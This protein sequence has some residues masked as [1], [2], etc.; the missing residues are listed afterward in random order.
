[1]NVAL[2]FPQPCPPP[3]PC[4]LAWFRAPQRPETMQIAYFRALRAPKPCK[5]RGFGHLRGLKPCKQ[6]GF[7]H[8]RGPKL[9]KQCTLSSAIELPEVL[10]NTTRNTAYY[11]VFWIGL[12]CFLA[13]ILHIIHCFGILVFGLLH[14]MPC[15]FLAGSLISAE[16]HCTTLSM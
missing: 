13:G 2:P 4:T 9:C 5:W 8:C 16:T 6:R 1:M 10:R 15:Y 3:K 12:V 11:A 7:G 14:L